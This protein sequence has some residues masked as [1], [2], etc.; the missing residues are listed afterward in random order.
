[1]E[2]EYGTGMGRSR[3]A[4]LGKQLAAVGAQPGGRREQNRTRK[5]EDTG[6][7]PTASQGTV[8]RLDGSTG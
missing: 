5:P 3:G 6:V 7:F 2:D 4:G 8:H 1:M